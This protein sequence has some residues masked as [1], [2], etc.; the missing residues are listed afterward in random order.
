MGLKPLQVWTNLTTVLLV[1]RKVRKFG[2]K[3]RVEK[4]KMAMDIWRQK[5]LES[6]NKNTFSDKFL[7]E[8]GKQGL[9]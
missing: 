1:E 3:L 7:K 4:T 2:L 8:P 5:F 6:C 9:S